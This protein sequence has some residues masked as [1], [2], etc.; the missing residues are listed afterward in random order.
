MSYYDNIYSNPEKYGATLIAEV[1]ADIGYEFDIVAVFANDDGTYGWAADSGCSCPIPF[2]GT[3]RTNLN[4]LDPDHP[5]HW[6]AL[7]DAAR[8][9][10]SYSYYGEDRDAASTREVKDF[11]KTVRSHTEAKD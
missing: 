7:E 2:E 3:T 1:S 5:D 8:S 10:V 11:I 9:C 4:R 6:R